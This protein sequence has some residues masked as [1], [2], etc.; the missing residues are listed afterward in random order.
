MDKP[1]KFLT[2][3]DC[4]NDAIKKLRPELSE[5]Q[6]IQTEFREGLTCPYC[7]KPFGGAMFYKV[8][9]S[10]EWI[11]ANEVIGCRNCRDRQ[12]F[13]YYQE[14]S[15]REQKLEI[16][17]RLM[18]EYFMLP[19]D[20]KNAGFQNYEKTDAVTSKA[21][22]SSIDYVNAYL[23]GDLFNLLIMGNPGT[24]KS[25]LCVA[26]ARN[27]QSKGKT[28]GFITTG[29]LLNKIK[30]TYSSNSVKT[31]EGIMQDIS[32][33][34]LF[35]LDDVGTESAGGSDDWRKSKL[36][37][38]VNS[39]IGKPTI[40]TSNLTDKDLPFA[41]GDRVFSRLYNNTKFIDLFT[42]DYRKKLKIK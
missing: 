4:C 10:E 3:Q 30:G 8:A 39:R 35:I 25:H 36:F 28:I 16:S 11:Q 5:Q 1:R 22:L 33:L 38:I 2:L 9:G 7:N 37:E 20:L 34:D 15:L 13:Y 23:K 19:E 29:K 6:G 40:Y 12:A 18:V 17:K 24:G 27:L 21:K 14:N 26:I 32:K 42:A 41:V 31:E